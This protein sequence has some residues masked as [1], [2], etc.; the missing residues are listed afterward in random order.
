MMH[1]MN[2]E[3]TSTPIRQT[4]INGLAIAGFVALV[5][6]GIWLAIYS[7]RFVPTAVNG[8]GAAAVYLGSVLTPTDDASISVAPTTQTTISFGNESSAPTTIT[9][10]ISPNQIIAQTAGEKTSGAYQ[11]GGPTTTNVLSGLPDFVVSIGAAGYLT[12]V[13]ADS[14][15]VSSTVPS[16]SRPAIKFTIK[17]IGANRSGGWRFSASIPTQ[18]AYIYQSPLQQSLNPG[19]R[20]DYT[21]GFDQPIA[22]ADKII[23]VIANF[24]NSV[25]ESNMDNNSA[26]AKLTILGG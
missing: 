10:P 19:D 14:F 1:H 21:L 26:S 20:I 18:T 5:A 13:S 8:V 9:T 3:Q 2:T 25:G 6:A 17:N 16:G 11:I 15:V 7:T 22:G 12:A 4:A 24:D 23:S